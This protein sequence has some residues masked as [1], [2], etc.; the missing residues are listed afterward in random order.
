[1][2]TNYPINPRVRAYGKA[3]IDIAK[4]AKNA[5]EWNKLWLPASN[6][7]P[8]VW[9]EAWKHCVEYKVEDFPAEVGFF[10]D[11][12]G[13]QINAFDPGYAM[14]TSPQGEFFFA[15]VPTHPGDRPTP[16]DAIRLQ[17]LVKDIL[18]TTR[19]LEKRGIDFDQAPQPI[20]PGSSVIISGFRTPNGIPVELWGVN[21]LAAPSEN[22]QEDLRQDKNDNEED[23]GDGE[24][25]EELLEDD[26][27]LEDDEGE[28][29]ES[30]DAD[31]DETGIAIDE[32]DEDEDD[33][34]LDSE[35]EDGDEVDEEADL[36][37]DLYD[38]ELD[39]EDFEL[40]EDEDDDG[41]EQ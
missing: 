16:T 18:A 1:M 12:L 14:F 20:Q 25:D 39:D 31:V 30:D 4:R 36:D 32:E 9:G 10:I 11:V 19:E 2:A 7:F 34:S 29:V 41:F 38:D 17:F 40:D 27:F 22:K 37:D 35:S 8:L 23:I 33:V 26:E 28:P 13:F 3:R 5:E 6:S 24:E 21:G 15:V